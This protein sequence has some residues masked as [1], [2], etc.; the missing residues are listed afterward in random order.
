MP[1]LVDFVAELERQKCLFEDAQDR[2]GRAGGA[3]LLRESRP[4]APAWKGAHLC[5]N[6]AF[7]TRTAPRRSRGDVNRVTSPL[8][9]RSVDDPTIEISLPH[10]AEGSTMKLFPNWSVC[11]A[12]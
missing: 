11:N 3:M 10:E 1:A 5:L 8:L 7:S 12:R 6:S 9:R 2:N 4:Q